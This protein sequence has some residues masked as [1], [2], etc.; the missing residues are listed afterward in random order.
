MVAVFLGMTLLIMGLVP[1]QEAQSK[2]K[3]E[4]EAAQSSQE[5]E[6]EKTT[7]AEDETQSQD[8]EEGEKTT[9]G[10]SDET[11]NKRV[12]DK[13]PQGDEYVAGEL[14]VTYEKSDSKQA[15]EEA[16]KTVGAKVEKDFPEMG[17]QHVSVPEV[18]NEKAKEVRQKA[19]ERKKK[20]LEQA[21]EVKAV[22]YN[23]VGKGTMVPSDSHYGRQWG[24]P[25]INAPKAWDFGSINRNNVKVAVLD[26]GIDMNHTDLKGKVVAQYDYVTNDY[27]ATDDRGHGTHVA[28]TIA[29][30]TNNTD[31][32]GNYLGVAGTCQS[33][34]LLNAKV[35]D[36][37]NQ[38]DYARYI[39]AI[40]WAVA[41]KANV[42]NMSFAHRV[43][44]DALE[45]AV[46]YAWNSGILLVASA[47]NLGDDIYPAA[48]KNVI[49][50]AATDSNDKRALFDDPKTTPYDQSNIGE[51]VD[52]AAPGKDIWST[53][54]GWYANGSGTSMAAPHVSG[55]A[56]LLFSQGQLS[57]GQ[58]RTAIEN[59]A[60]DLGA[61]GK[62]NAFGYGRIDAYYS[63]VY[64]KPSTYSQ[65]SSQISYSGGD[66]KTY[67]WS[68][69]QGTYTDTKWASR[70]GATA[71]FTFNGNSVSWW[72]N[73]GPYGGKAK[74]YVDS[75]Y[76]GTADL[77]A[78]RNEPTQPVFSKSWG[79]DYTNQGHTI[80]IV[81]EGTSGHPWV[82]VDAITTTYPHTNC[83]L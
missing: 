82:D 22:D 9:P 11:Q 73:R 6:Q 59:Q 3:K 12:L 14:L 36:K 68:D 28:G 44:S 71:K 1:P 79:K 10:E 8:Q 38:G 20:D 75:V 34:Q 27:D 42:I 53:T 57:N 7:P 69:Y 50:V 76:E 25:K 58:V 40:H 51:Y 46:D 52:V 24:F 66:W 18:K 21:P 78:G 70:S 32:G 19:L 48:Y 80:E 65:D 39:Y 55:L 47:G 54:P 60:R 45:S 33:C 41:N 29:A 26:S 81:V 61:W 2:E 72:A 17:V 63:I 62:D 23:Y 37:D 56:G 43:P 30:K 31:A 74:V 35:L 49:A 13:D 15:N 16:P 77:Y 4:N 67:D 5:Q 83:C 64:T